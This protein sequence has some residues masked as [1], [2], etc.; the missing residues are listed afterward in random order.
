[1]AESEWLCKSEEGKD[2]LGEPVSRP[3]ARMRASKYDVVPEVW[4]CVAVLSI[5]HS[6]DVIA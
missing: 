3:T 1:M 5:M 4:K 2:E 6:M